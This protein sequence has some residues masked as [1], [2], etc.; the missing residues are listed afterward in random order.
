[1]FDVRLVRRFRGSLFQRRQRVVCGLPRRRKGVRPMDQEAFG[2][3][4]R[5]LRESQRPVKS[6]AVVSELCGMER[7]ALRRYER[8]ERLP[9]IAAMIALADYYGV[10]LDYL[11]GR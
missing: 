3:R 8:G 2:A 4:L 7:S 9:S 6:M 1:M 5:Q 11:A 10:T